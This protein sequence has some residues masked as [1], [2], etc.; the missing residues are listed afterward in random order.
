VS[1]HGLDGQRGPDIP[2]D[3]DLRLLIREV[4]AEVLARRTGQA[5]GRQATPGA[6][7]TAGYGARLSPTPPGPM[8]PTAV[9]AGIVDAEPPVDGPVPGAARPGG[10]GRNRSSQTGRGVTVRPVRLQT[11]EDVRQFALELV[12][13]ADNPARRRDL[14]AGRL[15]FTLASGP[16]ATAGVAGMAGGEAGRIESGAVTERTVQAAARNGRR[17]VLGPRAVLT[18]LAR[19]RAQALGVLIERER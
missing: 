13:L 7:P 5:P 1:T 4:L 6:M 14:F 12:R 9:P 10:P 11:D 17:L 8:P 19:D 2:A 16:A 15:S 18:P 3:D